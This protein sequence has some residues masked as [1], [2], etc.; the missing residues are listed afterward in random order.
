[1]GRIGRGVGLCQHHSILIRCYQ[2]FNISF[3]FSNEIDLF[4]KNVFENDLNSPT[5]MLNWKRIPV[6]GGNTVLRDLFTA[7][8]NLNNTTRD[9]TLDSHLRGRVE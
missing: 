5:A 6:S 2:F 3:L 8:Y 4:K 7:M 9:I 1:V